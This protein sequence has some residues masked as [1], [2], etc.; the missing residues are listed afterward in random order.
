VPRTRLPIILRLCRRRVQ[1]IQRK[2]VDPHT[3]QFTQ[4]SNPYVVRSSLW[5]P[6]RTGR[7][8]VIALA[9]RFGWPG[10][11]KGASGLIRLPL[12]YLFA[13]I[14]MARPTIAFGSDYDTVIPNLREPYLPDLPQPN[15]FLQ[16]HTA[17][18]IGS[19]TPHLQMRTM[20]CEKNGNQPSEGRFYSDNQFVFGRTRVIASAL[21]RLARR[22]RKAQAVA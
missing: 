3:P 20:R 9:A 18:G 1:T 7:V 5:L 2:S 12:Y 8:M 4:T 15:G 16:S 22:K 11:R 10:K 14:E 19:R 6:L 17:C 13:S 21:A